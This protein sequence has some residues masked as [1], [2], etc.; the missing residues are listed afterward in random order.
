MYP[1]NGRSNFIF[2]APVIPCSYC[3][4][5]RGSDQHVGVGMTITSCNFR[6]LSVLIFPLNFLLV[7]TIIAI[8]I[9]IIIRPPRWSSG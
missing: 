9:I 1:A 7:F 5:F 4:G 8:I 6:S 3:I 2:I